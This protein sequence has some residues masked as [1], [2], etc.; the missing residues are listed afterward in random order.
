MLLH[1]FWLN[2][3]NTAFRKCIYFHS[4]I[5]EKFFNITNIETTHVALLKITMLFKNF[6][7]QCIQKQSLLVTHAYNTS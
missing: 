4:I 2:P 5:N 6:F 1:V 3:M 7:K